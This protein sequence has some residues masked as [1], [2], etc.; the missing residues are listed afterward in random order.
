M[1]MKNKVISRELEKRWKGWTGTLHKQIQ[2]K[3][4][5]KSLILNNSYNELC[6][7]YP[8]LLEKNLPVESRKVNNAIKNIMQVMSMLNEK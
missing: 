5:N 2:M 6:E 4:I 3:H 8:V 7:V 1:K